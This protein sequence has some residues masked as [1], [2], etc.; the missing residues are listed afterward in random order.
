MPSRWEIPIQGV[1][2]LSVL[3][4]GVHSF[5]SRWF[6]DDP[7]THNA[8]KPYSLSGIRSEGPFV[9]LTVSLI[10]DRLARRVAALQPGE[11]I[12][13]GTQPSGRAT[14]A[15]GPRML[16]ETS[17]DELASLPAL[18][19]WRLEL[20]SPT[21]FRRGAVS[22][23]WPDPV[24]V[25]ECLCANWTLGTGVELPFAPPEPRAIAVTHADLRTKVSL[26]AP[27]PT[28]GAIG[29]LRWM[30]VPNRKYAPDTEGAAAV[31]RL[32]GLAEFSGVGAYTQ[33]GMGRVTVRPAGQRLQELSCRC[34]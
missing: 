17:W 3:P 5:L 19:G 7:V 21:C 16:R 34:P 11:P 31:T 18:S 25:I 1:D 14:V 20:R 9:V 13:F 15:D 2:G 8:P 33:F 22:Q 32:L 28:V 12:Q 30:W 10:A 23:P 27:V 6:E 24:R 26:S 29:G 4:S